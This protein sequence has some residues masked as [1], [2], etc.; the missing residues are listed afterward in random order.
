MRSKVRPQSGLSN[1]STLFVV[2]GIVV[3]ALVSIYAVMRWKESPA[4]IAKVPLTIE[5]TASPEDSEIFVDGKSMGIS[6]APLAFPAG[7][8]ELLVSR[9]GYRSWQQAFEASGTLKIPVILQPIPMDLKIL[10]GQDKA[11]IWLDDAPQ[12]GSPDSA[13][14]WTLNGVSP[15]THSVR[16]KTAAGESTVS[17]DFRNSNPAAPIFPET[18]PSI[19]FVSSSDGKVRAECNCKAEL[20]LSDSSQP[21]EPGSAATFM[22]ADGKYPAELKGLPDAKSAVGITVG[23]TAETTMAFFWPAPV[24]EKKPVVDIQ[25]LLNSSLNLLKDSKCDAAQANI[26]QVLSKSPGNADAVGLSR[27]ITRLRSVG[28]CR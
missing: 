18:G 26:D 2:L 3:L 6:K 15:G 20:Q 14:T 28:G 27:R 7:K 17:F 4:Q 16:I 9:R 11:E 13:G 5:V 12:A 19:L 24:K 1:I 21:L 10:P 23:P 25:A 22:L 8:H